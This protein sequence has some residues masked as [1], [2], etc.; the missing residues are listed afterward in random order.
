[1]LDER[2]DNAVDIIE[3]ISRKAKQTKFTSRVDTVLDKDDPSAEVALAEI[4]MKL[5]AVR[6]SRNLANTIL[7]ISYL[8]NQETTHVH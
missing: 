3:D 7:E 4:Q 2:P 5:F 6:V 1:V 8:L